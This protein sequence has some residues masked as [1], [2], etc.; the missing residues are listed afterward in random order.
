MTTGPGPRISDADREAAAARLREHYAQGRLTLEEFHRRLDAVFDATTQS[1]L[2]AI[3]RDL[4]RNESPVPLPST[5][6]GGGRERAR[7]QHRP[8]SRARPDVIPVIIA[9]LAAWLLVSRLHLGIFTWPGR[10]ALFLMIF[11]AIRWLIRFLW[12]LGRGA[13]P[14]GGG[15]R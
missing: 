15:R 2:T 4:P 13:G 12:G 14:M 8:G 9:V 1:Q 7:Q 11:A 3:A 6:T 10:I 5:G